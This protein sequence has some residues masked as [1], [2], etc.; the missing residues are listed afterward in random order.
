MKIASWNVNSVNAR[1]PSIV[2]WLE[3]AQPDMI[4]LQEI[5]CVDEKFPITEIEGLGYNV[6]VHGQKSYNGVA[7]L[8]KLP[9]DEIIPGLPGDNEDMQARYLEVVVS[10]QGRALRL[11][12]IYLPNGN[13]V[14]TEKYSYK[15]AWMERLKVHAGE[16]LRYEEPLV[17]AGDY[18]VIPTENDVTNP[19]NWRDDALFLPQTRAAYNEILHMGFTDAFMACDGRAHQYTFWDY[20]G[21]AWQ[22]DRGLRIDHLLLSPQAADLLQSCRIDRQTRGWERPSDHVPIWLELDF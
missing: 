5:K 10:G 21:G 8:S 20:K 15:L 13:P 11:A 9:F 1:L 3:Q 12:S 18:N 22:K 19:E 4:C 16:L 17:L 7:I 14:A 2:A 6:A